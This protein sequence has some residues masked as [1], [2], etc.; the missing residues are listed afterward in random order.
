MKENLRFT[1]G[2]NWSRY[3]RIISDKMINK[4]YNDFSNLLPKNIN[5]SNMS[6]LDIGCGSGIHSLAAIKKGFKELECVDYDIDSVSTT[7]SNLKKF[8]NTNN[9]KVYKDDILN[10]KITKKFDLVYSWGVLHHTGNLNKAVSNASNLVSN[11]GF[12]IISIYKKTYFCN[13]WK[14]I[15]RFSNKII[16]FKLFFLLFY[17]PIFLI[18]LIIKRKSLYTDRGMFFYYDVIDWVVGYPYESATNE[19]IVKLLK[20]DFELINIYNNSKPAINGLLGTGCAE[21]VFQKK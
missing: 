7:I 6:F 1:F 11:N 3:S 5:C 17:L 20:N 4:S 21:Y 14:F 18:L 19:E 2:K 12:F 15:K 9:Y 13:L 16:L 8:S 10:S